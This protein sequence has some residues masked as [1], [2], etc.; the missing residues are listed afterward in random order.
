MAAENTNRANRARILIGLGP[1]ASRMLGPGVVRR[2]GRRELEPLADALTADVMSELPDLLA[3][4]LSVQAID[5][6]VAERVSCPFTAL[7]QVRKLVARC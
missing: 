3:P 2:A 1:E 4:E 7:F 6:I 5:D